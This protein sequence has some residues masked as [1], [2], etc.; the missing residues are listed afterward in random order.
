MLWGMRKDPNIV[1]TRDDDAVRYEKKLAR[2][3]DKKIFMGLSENVV[4]V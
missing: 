4:K 1:W 3:K 2:V